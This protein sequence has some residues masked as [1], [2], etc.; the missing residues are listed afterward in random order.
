M[1]DDAFTPPVAS[2]VTPSVASS[3]TPPVTPPVAPSVTPSVAPSITPS[4]TRSFTPFPSPSPSSF[5]AA[6]TP[7]VHGGIPHAELRTLGLGADD[8]LDLSASCNPYGPCDLVLDAIRAAPVDRYPDPTAT[9]ARET[10]AAALGV[11]AEHIA[12]GNGAAE[13][14]W[15]LA[16]V[17]IRSGAGVVIVEP[18]FCELRLAAEHAGGQIHDWR[19]RP[20]DGFAVD[21]ARAARLIHQRAAA[22]V[23]LCAPGTP[24][25]AAVPA[26]QVAAL[27]EAHR[28][29]TFVL[30]Q[31]F[32]SL[33]ERFA[34]AAI[35]Q[36][37]NVACVRSLTKDLA[38]PGVRVGYVI[39]APPLIARI[40]RARAAWTT[41][42]AAQAAAIAACGAGAF[43]AASRARLLA[44]RAA[45]AAG[46]A[47]LGLAP[48]PSSTGYLVAH[49][50]DARA[51]RRRL[52]VEHAILVR[53]CT[54]FGLPDHVRIAARPAAERE[55]LFAALAA[56]GALR[57][58][59]ARHPTE[60]ARPTGASR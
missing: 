40:E 27:A 16:S 37:P 31:S 48:A 42:A 50:G 51:V 46:L 32:L 55:R 39:A 3:V 4:V 52:L 29:T 25:G 28:A 9:T 12:L 26:A 44:D 15:T 35:A 10:L 60:A 1:P 45:L 56:I 57:P 59:G 47:A 33:S 18:A 23:Y 38:I 54:S 5:P 19:A 11:T 49:V 41:G 17:L 53:D 8:V 6:L 34:D 7:R 30:D 2:S 22:V 58:T 20:E 13:L 36:P 21:L 24:T 14:L 43:V